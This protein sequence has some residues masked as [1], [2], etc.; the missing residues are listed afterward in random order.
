MIT[1][2]EGEKGLNKVII[3]SDTFLVPGTV[4]RALQ[5]LF[6]PQKPSEGG[7][8]IFRVFYRMKLR[9]VWFT[10]LSKCCENYMR[11]HITVLGLDFVSYLKKK[12]K[13]REKEKDPN[14]AKKKKNQYFEQERHFSLS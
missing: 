3:I 1:H 14:K 11:N 8:V 4:L 6:N 7:P 2:R 9:F 12:R 10:K 5:G 13:K